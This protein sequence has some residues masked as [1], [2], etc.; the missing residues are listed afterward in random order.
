MRLLRPC[1]RC[2]VVVGVVKAPVP[3]YLG[4]PSNHENMKR[5]HSQ[6][7]RTG[8]EYQVGGQATPITHSLTLLAHHI[9][10]IPYIPPFTMAYS[11]DRKGEW[12]LVDPAV[13]LS[14]RG[15]SRH[16]STLSLLSLNHK[17]PLLL[18]LFTLTSLLPLP[19]RSPIQGSVSPSRF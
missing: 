4:F 12:A 15:C 3:A 14:P 11:F 6:E 5:F 16:S 19:L 1:P 13:R 10:F 9:P 18:S 2:V 8:P 17:D 7:G